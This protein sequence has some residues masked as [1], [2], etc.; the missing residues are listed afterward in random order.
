MNHDPADGTGTPAIVRLRRALD[1]GQHTGPGTPRTVV[2]M[3]GERDRLWNPEGRWW[4]AVVGPLLP[5]FLCDRSLLVGPVHIGQEKGC[6]ECLARRWQQLRPDDYRDALESGARFQSHAANP[7]L[8]DFAL[9]AARA[10]R[11]AVAAQDRSARCD[12]AGNPYVHRLDLATL[13]LRRYPLLQDA[14]CPGCTDLPP[15]T[16]W[17]AAFDLRPRPK[18]RSDAL[19]V[20][21]TADYPIPVAALT[22]PVCGALG[23]HATLRVD[24]TTTAPAVG[25]A[26]VRGSGYLHPSFW[27]GHADTFRQSLRLGL[28]EG[29]ER[30]AGLSPRGS[31]PTVR[32]GYRDLSSTALDPNELGVYAPSFYAHNFDYQPFSEET[33]LTWV[34]GYSLRDQCPVLVPE[35]SVYYHGGGADRKIAQEC[36]NGCAT[37]GS[38][39]EA[40]LHGVLERVERDAFLLA[41]YGHLPLTEVDPETW[42]SPAIRWMV[43][44]LGLYGY[45]ARFFDARVD[46]AIP[47]VIA[48]AERKDTGPGMLCFGA[49]AS[50][51]P[52]EAAESAIREVAFEVPNAE[53]HTVHARERLLAMAADFRRVRDLADHPRL[54]G[55]PEMRSYAD[56]I[57]GPRGRRPHV[58]PADRVYR[59]WEAERPL[60]HD[61][62]DDLRFCRD[63]LADAGVDCIAVDQTSAEEE[64]IG[65][66]TVC[67]LTPGL[68]PID[69]GW[70]RQRA[71]MMPRLRR[72]AAHARRP[73]STVAPHPFP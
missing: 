2:G 69:F 13:E 39:E 30:S 14:H 32:A 26:S 55:L 57:L 17:R 23:A 73:A 33:P 18:P 58:L 9:G 53:A 44:R 65:V 4:R 62:T 41:W 29:L 15:D 60:Y 61:L 12:E 24:N 1:D 3:L 8:S 20:S 45:R 48:V 35:V 16:E 11:D 40:A 72:V 10:L 70:D 56:H 64:R 7:Y 49:G 43:H 50:L 19:R 37:G 36:S 66:H 67:V 5:V 51:A 42:C 71:L 25:Y 54:Y 22:N 59:S 47:V 52:E 46:F 68:L 38:R 63:L 6:P 34:W 21:A 28:L 27:G 31:R